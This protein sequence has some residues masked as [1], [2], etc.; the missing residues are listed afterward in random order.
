MR[1]FVSMAVTIEDCWRPHAV[2]QSI[3]ALPKCAKDAL[4][5]LVVDRILAEEVS[6]A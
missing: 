6:C 4:L 5:R 3:F 1:T 2:R